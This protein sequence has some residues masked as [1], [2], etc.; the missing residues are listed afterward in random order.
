MT[1]DDWLARCD[2]GH[3]LSWSGR[4]DG[5]HWR[6]EITLA[7]GG[8]YR[9]TVVLDNDFDPMGGAWTD[10]RTTVLT[11]AAA[12]AE[13]ALLLQHTGEPLVRSR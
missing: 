2:D 4:G 9:S 1:P 7:P 13:I 11:L 10:E 6:Q 5:G 12:R 3:T 8:G